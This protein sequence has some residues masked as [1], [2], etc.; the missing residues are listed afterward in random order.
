[1]RVAG[2]PLPH[3]ARFTRGG[4]RSLS[5]Q[6]ARAPARRAN[7]A[8]IERNTDG[9]AATSLSP[10]NR[11]PRRLQRRTAQSRASG[12]G[13]EIDRRGGGALSR[14]AWRSHGRDNKRSARRI[15]RGRDGQAAG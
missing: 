13:L 10:E 7:R 15:R 12:T 11:R 6:D 3:G 5:A 8:Q 4:G 14:Y 9:G 1:M 2:Y